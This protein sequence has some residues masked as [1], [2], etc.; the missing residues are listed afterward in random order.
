MRIEVVTLFPEMVYHAAQ[1]GVT[2]RALDRGLWSLVC[3]NPRDY[4]SDAYRSVDAGKSWQRVD[5]GAYKGALQ[6]ATEL[7]D[8]TVVLTGADGMVATSTDNGASF[9]AKPVPSRVTVT[10]VARTN[11]HWLVAGPSGLR[12]VK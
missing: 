10:A 2:G 9:I 1:Y 6:G 4:A 11:G 12:T 8:G 7:A 3:R 5:L